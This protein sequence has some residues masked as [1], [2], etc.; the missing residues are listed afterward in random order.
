[1]NPLKR[2]S[3]N[4]G[5]YFVSIQKWP[6]CPISVSIMDIKAYKVF[7]LLLLSLLVFSAANAGQAQYEIWRVVFTNTQGT[8]IHLNC[9]VADTAEKRKRG[10]M[11]RD[12]LDPDSGMIFVY[13]SPSRLRFWMKNTKIPLSIAFIDADGYIASIRQMQ[14]NSR[15]ITASFQ[16]VKYAVEANRGWFRKNSI[17]AGSNVK[18]IKP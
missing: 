4:I 15:N 7:S 9:E 5:R 3:L 2:S 1:M 10:L 17:K 12:H 6:I 16:R 8:D 13:R 14:P 11:Y 18:F